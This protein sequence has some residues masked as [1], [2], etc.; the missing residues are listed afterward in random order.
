M[1][2]LLA[3]IQAHEIVYILEAYKGQTAMSHYVFFFTVYQATYHADIRADNIW[4]MLYQ[5]EGY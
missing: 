1:F 4:P 3:P 5:R 2:L